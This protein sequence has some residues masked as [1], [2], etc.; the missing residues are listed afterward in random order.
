MLKPTQW[1]QYIEVMRRQTLHAICR[2]TAQI[3]SI[4][5][6]PLEPVH[7]MVR[8]LQIN[9]LHVGWL[10]NLRHSGSEEQWVLDYCCSN[11]PQGCRPGPVRAS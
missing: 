2:E 10:T 3:T 8:T 11:Y 6:E 9:P 1:L 7:I 4:H 5:S